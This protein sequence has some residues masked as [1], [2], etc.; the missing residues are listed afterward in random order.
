MESYL[1]SAGKS[2]DELRDELRDRATRCLVSAWVIAEV[3]EQEGLQVTPEDVDQEIDRMVEESGTQAEVIRQTFADQRL[4]ES[5]SQVVLARKATRRLAL[6]AV[7]SDESKSTDT[8][9]EISE[10]ELVQAPETLDT[11]T[12]GATD[13]DELQS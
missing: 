6:I 10:Q 5:L 12:G 8:I 7:G 2:T 13:A 1:E 3:A 9:P 11:P 4:R